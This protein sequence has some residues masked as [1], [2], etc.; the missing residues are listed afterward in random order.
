[1]NIIVIDTNILRALGPHFFQ[2]VD[3]LS[4]QDYCYSS[5][6]EIVIPSTVQREYLDYY[7]KEIIEKNLTDIEMAVSRLSKLEKFKNIQNL[8][9]GE[10]VNEQLGFIENKLTENRLKPILETYLSE[11][12]LLDFLIDN[13]QETKKD[14]TRDFIIWTNTLQIAEKYPDEQIVLISKDKIFQENSHFTQIIKEREIN[15]LTVFESIA[16]FLSIYGFKSETLNKELI[17]NSIPVSIIQEELEKDKSS[18]PSHI[19]Q[20]YYHTRRDFQLEK[21][22]IQQIEIEEYYAHKEKDSEN[23][24]VIA[25]VLVK[26]LMVFEPE[27]NLHNLNEYLNN[28]GKGDEKDFYPNTFDKDGRPIFDEWILFHFGLEFNENEKKIEKTEFY[29]FFPEDANFRRMKA[30][31]NNV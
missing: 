1:M 5:A 25:H 30:A 8:N 3:Y 16:S 14:N 20:F 10:S 4:L 27:K 24:K 13:K 6:S 7:K 23:V 17:L 29:D 12:E 28:L 18:I 31:H 9:L 15:N 21:F 26:V 19:S 11:E 2:K 22:E